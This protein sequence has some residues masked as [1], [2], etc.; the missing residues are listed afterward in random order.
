MEKWRAREGHG[1]KT[2]VGLAGAALRENEEFRRDTGSPG[3]G[4]TDGD[5]RGNKLYVREVLEQ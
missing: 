1:R 2:R 4:Y 5:R 3:F